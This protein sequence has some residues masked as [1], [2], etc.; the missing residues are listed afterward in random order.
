M[1]KM[2]E[3]EDATRILK[4]ATPK[5][6]KAVSE[7]NKKMDEARRIGINDSRYEDSCAQ[8]L[9]FDNFIRDLEVKINAAQKILD[10]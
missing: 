3:R 10:K 2:G 4:E 5:M 8:I 1:K 7:R 9:V 6:N